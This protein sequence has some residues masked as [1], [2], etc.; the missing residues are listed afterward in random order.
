ML[1]KARSEVL[2]DGKDGSFTVVIPRWMMEKYNFD[3]PPNI[4]IECI[5]EGILIKK[6]EIFP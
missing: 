4:I 1:R 3:E 2:S 6:L 5:R